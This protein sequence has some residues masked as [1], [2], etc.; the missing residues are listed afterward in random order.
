[1]HHLIIYAIKLNIILFI[2]KFF[3]GKIGIPIVHKVLGYSD[4]MLRLINS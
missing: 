1:M 4:E 3:D 2:T